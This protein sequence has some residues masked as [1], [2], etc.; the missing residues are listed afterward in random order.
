MR[1]GIDCACTYCVLIVFVL[2]G[3]GSGWGCL[4]FCCFLCV[5]GCFVAFGFVFSYG[6]LDG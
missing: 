6:C 3:F 4:R 2:A 5:I 1:F